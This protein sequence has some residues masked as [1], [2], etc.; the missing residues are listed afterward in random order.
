MHVHVCCDTCEHACV[1]HACVQ[2]RTSNACYVH[3]ACVCMYLCVYL[4]MYVYVC[5]YVCMYVLMYVC[6]YA[7]GICM[8]V[9]MHARMLACN[10]CLSM[11]L[12]CTTYMW[13]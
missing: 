6:M 13:V 1:K 9:C 11:H 7:L 12:V 10:V 2:G 8:H 4:C 5:I 3:D